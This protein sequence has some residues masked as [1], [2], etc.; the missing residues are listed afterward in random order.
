MGFGAWRFKY[1]VMFLLSGRLGL[2][3]AELGLLARTGRLSWRAALWCVGLGL[4][5]QARTSRVAA[6][7]AGMGRGLRRMLR[8]A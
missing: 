3:F 1:L 2:F 8:T 7:L 6:A 5:V 4:H